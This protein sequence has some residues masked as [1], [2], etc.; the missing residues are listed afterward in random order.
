MGVYHSGVL[1]YRGRLRTQ[2]YTW[3]RIVELSYKG[4]DF[5]MV[6]RPVVFDEYFE[7][8]GGGSSRRRT[9]ASSAK[10]NGFA[11]GVGDAGSVGGSGRST[12]E[13]GSAKQRSRSAKPPSYAQRQRTII[14]KCL[15]GELAKRLYNIVVDHHTFFR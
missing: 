15:N 12:D 1:V 8:P 7:S 11:G 14:F 2:R 6:V 3:A 13:R 5:I 9:S 4:K 10:S